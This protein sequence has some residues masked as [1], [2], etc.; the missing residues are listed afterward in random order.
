MALILKH[1]TAEQLIARVRQALAIVAEMRTIRGRS[2]S[3]ASMPTCTAYGS[4]SR[5]S[6]ISFSRMSSA[7]SSRSVLSVNVPASK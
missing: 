4:S 7:T 3:K 1:Q 6:S 5:V 2:S